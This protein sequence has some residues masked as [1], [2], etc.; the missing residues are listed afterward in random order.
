QRTRQ[1]C[2]GCWGRWALV[3]S[4]FEV[5]NTGFVLIYPVVQLVEPFPVS[6][7]FLGQL[8]RGVN[9]KAALYE[10]SHACHNQCANHQYHPT[11]PPM[12]DCSGVTCSSEFSLSSL[13]CARLIST[14]ARWYSMSARPLLMKR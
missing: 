5:G 6:R 8:P 11:P 1:Y 14:W 13:L 7:Y 4:A 9:C 3:Q 12:R 2:A 10:H